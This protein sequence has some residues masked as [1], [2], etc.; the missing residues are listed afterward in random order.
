MKQIVKNA[1]PQALVDWKA[2][3]NENWKPTYNDLQNP[4]KQVVVQA[5]LEEQGYICCHCEKSIVDV[6]CHIEHFLPQ[7]HYPHRDLEYRNLHL[8]CVKQCSTKQKE[9]QCCGHQKGN[10]LLPISPLDSEDRDRFRFNALGKILVQDETDQ[11][12]VET[13]EILNL[14]S[15]SL[16]Q[17]R[18]Y[19]IDEFTVEE[20][21]Q[22][23]E[24]FREFVA[25]ELQL[26]NG[27][28]CEFWSTIHYHF[29]TSL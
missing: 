27:K 5:L 18:K 23:E 16:R 15:E 10:R 7:E 20:E 17:A 21:Q 6:D 2:L 4:E 29:G 3:E 24:E 1:E 22:S 8:S 11:D 9:E 25:D 28:Y 12:A 19:I 14:N 13:I 26:K